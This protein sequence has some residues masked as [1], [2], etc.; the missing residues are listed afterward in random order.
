[1]KKERAIPLVVGFALALCLA[2]CG[3]DPAQE[4]EAL[5]T[6][7]AEQVGDLFCDRVLSDEIYMDTLKFEFANGSYVEDGLYQVDASFPGEP[8]AGSLSVYTDD[9]G[10]VTKAVLTGRVQLVACM[11]ELFFSLGLPSDFYDYVSS[12]SVADLGEEQSW[13][14]DGISV[15]YECSE[16]GYNQELSVFV[17]Q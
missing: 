6:F 15:H 9:S 1:M 10:A 12:T 13:E 5:S 11:E 4:T 14:R 7:T 8:N 16:D 3:E 17:A 2:G